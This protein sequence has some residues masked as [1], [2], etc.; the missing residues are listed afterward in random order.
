MTNLDGMVVFQHDVLLFM[1]TVW[2]Y[3]CT[4]FLGFFDCWYGDHVLVFMVT[5]WHHGCTVFFGF[6]DCRYGDHSFWHPITWSI[7][8]TRWTLTLLLTLEW[9]KF[10]SD[11]VDCGEPMTSMVW[12]LLNVLWEQDLQ[13]GYA[14]TFGVYFSF[15]DY[16]WFRY[17]KSW[18]ARV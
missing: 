18:N 15:F 4:V 12:C 8:V 17:I 14:M 1:V 6:F 10:S 13:L 11:M 2:H 7:I 9:H 5:V 3:G 16:V